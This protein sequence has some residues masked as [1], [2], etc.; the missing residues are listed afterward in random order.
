MMTAPYPRNPLAVELDFHSTPKDELQAY[1][2]RFITLIPERL[3]VLAANVK[4]LHGS[5]RPDL[6]PGSLEEV[7]SW[8]ISVTAS[9]PQT[10]TEA[11][12][13]RARIPFDLDL[14][15][16]TLTEDTLSYAMDAGMYFA[17]TL[18]QQRPSLEWKLLLGDRRNF[19]YGQPVLSGFKNKDLSVNPVRLLT[20]VCY[21]VIR[22]QHTPGRLLDL[23]ARWRQM[24]SS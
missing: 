12:I 17:E 24:S 11:A 15:T 9:R 3:R 14:P 5:W 21:G 7:E 4:R 6:T 23:L 10:P 2:S 20:N 18:R 13:E 22:G 8:L 19:D 1:F 16:D